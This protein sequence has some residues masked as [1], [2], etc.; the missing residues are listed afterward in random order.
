[1][2]PVQKYLFWNISKTH[3]SATHQHY[4]HD[5]SIVDSISIYDP[6]LYQLSSALVWHPREVRRWPPPTALSQRVMVTVKKWRAE[7]TSGSLSV[8]RKKH[9]V[10]YVIYRNNKYRAFR[11]SSRIYEVLATAKYRWYLPEHK[12]FMSLCSKNRSGG[13]L[14]HYQQRRLC[15]DM[16]TTPW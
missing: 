14:L 4:S 6:E 2:Y 3:V 13:S 8:M 9:V 11:G 10:Q 12:E 5:N 16:S 1:M 7:S 15:I